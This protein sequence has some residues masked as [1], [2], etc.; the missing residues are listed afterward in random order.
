[1][2]ASLIGLAQAIVTASPTGILDALGA[3]KEAAA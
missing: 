1:M 3:L 2:F